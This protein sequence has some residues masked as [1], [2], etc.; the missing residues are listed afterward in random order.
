MKFSATLSAL[1]VLVAAALVEAAGEDLQDSLTLSPDQVQPGLAQ[2]GQAVPV[3][4][5]VASLTSKNNFINHCATLPNLPLTNGQQIITGSCNPTIM[6]QIIAKDKMPSAKIISPVNL[7]QI[8]AGTPFQFKVKVRNMKTGNFVNANQ[9]YFAAPQQA[10]GNGI[11][12]AHS[13]ITVNKISSFQDSEP[14]DP[15]IFAFFKGL[16]DP[17]VNGVLTA[18]VTGGLDAG[19]YRACTINS[20]SNHQP[21]LVAVAQHASLDDCT[22]FEVTAGGK[23]DTA[24]NKPAL[25]PKGSN[26]AQTNVKTNKPKGKGGR[27]RRPFGRGRQ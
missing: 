14:A 7:A 6:G 12:L 5:Q 2:D 22:Y 20:S 25:S 27:S 4:G 17:A 24:A 10:D 26:G 16:N 18:D 21:A 11:L 19:F 15:T 8:A 23:D 3:A 1:A 9:N 13:H